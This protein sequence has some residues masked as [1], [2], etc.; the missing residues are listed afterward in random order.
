MGSSSQTVEELLVE[1]EALRAR[2]ASLE[3][4]LNEIE[5]VLEHFLGSPA[6]LLNLPEQLRGRQVA[7]ATRAS[8]ERAS[9]RAAMTQKVEELARAHAQLRQLDR[10]K[11]N[12]LSLISHELRTPISVIVGY[13]G[14]LEDEAEA[15]SPDQQHAFLQKVSDEAE[16]LL[17]LVNNVLDMNR[18]ITGELTLDTREV[19]FAEIVGNVTRQLGPVAEHKGVELVVQV[20][21]GLPLLL[22][23]EQR[24]G[25]VLHNLIDN[26]IKF[27]P[28]G[29]K[30]WVRA[31]AAEGHLRC[32]VQDTGIGIE[33]EDAARLFQVFGQLDSS[34]TRLRGGLGLGLALV[35]ELVT[36][37]GGTVG[38]FSTLEKGS[39]FWFQVPLTSPSSAT[40]SSLEA[41]KHA[42]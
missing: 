17:A 3:G 36:L 27:T 26:G 21:D 30:V 33:Q 29:G 19:S 14:I 23:D 25:Q 28:P 18:L 41:R 38:V 22:S 5:Q 12:F 24:L 1:L 9:A 8:E 31:Q 32:E 4:Q 11:Q 40:A 13:A 2:N 37:M 34:A 10:M 15:I 20:P 6:N 42:S 16:K 7:V 39:T 35:R